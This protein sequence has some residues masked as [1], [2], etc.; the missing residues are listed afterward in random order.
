MRCLEENGNPKTMN[1]KDQNF[2]RN[3]ILGR[4]KATELEPPEEGLVWQEEMS[5]VSDGLSY[6]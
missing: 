4:R 2:P 5:Q 1:F 6:S 3:L